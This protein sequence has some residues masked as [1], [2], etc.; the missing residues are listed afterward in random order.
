MNKDLCPRVIQSCGKSK[1]SWVQVSPLRV[2]G[3]SNLSHLSLLFSKMNIYFLT[4]CS[5]FRCIGYDRIT[6]SNRL[7]RRGSSSLRSLSITLTLGSVWPK[8]LNKA[9]HCTVSASFLSTTWWSLV[10]LTS[11]SLLAVPAGRAPTAFFINI[12]ICLSASYCSDMI[13]C[14]SVD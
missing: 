6:N 4:G 7:G 13:L 8:N 9:L 2:L 14:C 12:H 10:W 5:C 1:R 3:L 11:S